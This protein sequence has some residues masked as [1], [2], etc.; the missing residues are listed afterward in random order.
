MNTPP[1]SR[2]WHQLNQHAAAQLPADFP[3]RVL[4]HIRLTR[5]ERT[6]PA[7]FFLHPFA[8]SAYTAAFCFVLVVIIHSR[9]TAKTNER[10]LAEW[11]EVAMQTASLDPL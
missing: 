9:S 7:R 10:H 2:A 6:G 1:E 4:R 5:A 8:V 3:D 11:H